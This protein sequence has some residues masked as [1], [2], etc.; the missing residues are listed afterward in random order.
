MPR[1]PLDLTEALVRGAGLVVDLCAELAAARG[2]TL[3]QAQLLCVLDERPVPMARLGTLLKISKSSTTGL[4]T[5]AEEAGLVARTTDE[6]DAR[7]HLV[8]LSAAGRDLGRAYREAVT[9]GLDDLLADVAAPGRETLRAVL[10]DV[11]QTHEARETW[12]TTSDER[13]GRDAP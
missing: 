11:V 7:S 8:T 9:V 10:S 5:R 12:V 2:L 4:V 13:D 6:H 3:Q 1:R